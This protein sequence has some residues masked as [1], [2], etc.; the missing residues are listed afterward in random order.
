M[1]VKYC[2][3]SLNCSTIRDGIPIDTRVAYME[4]F[5]ISSKKILMLCSSV[6]MLGMH[7]NDGGRM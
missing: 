6:V 2:L 4:K 5:F 3:N 1:L 7:C